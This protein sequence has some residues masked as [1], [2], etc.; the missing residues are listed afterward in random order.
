[1]SDVSTKNLRFRAHQ[2][3]FWCG[4]GY[5]SKPVLVPA[6]LEALSQASFKVLRARRI[7]DTP[8]APTPPPF[9][10]E[11][12]TSR[13]G[14]ASRSRRQS[15]AVGG[16]SSSHGSAGSSPSPS[17]DPESTVLATVPAATAVSAVTAVARVASPAIAPPLVPQ[18]AQDSSN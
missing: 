17:P 2:Q 11:L 16:R 7:T 13:L 12:P 10:L 9:E 18:S 14:R 4:S 1:M 8:A 3:H 15:G 5:V 6:L